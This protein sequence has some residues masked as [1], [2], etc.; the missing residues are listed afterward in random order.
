MKQQRIDSQHNFQLY[1]V[2]AG[3]ITSGKCYETSMKNLFAHFR[4]N[5]FGKVNDY[6]ASSI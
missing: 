5:A 4:R 1:N 2:L 3:K 6:N